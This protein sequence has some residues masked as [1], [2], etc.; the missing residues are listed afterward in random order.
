MILFL[1][2]FVDE[3]VFACFGLVVIWWKIGSCRPD[4]WTW[5]RIFSVDR[6]VLAA[7]FAVLLHGFIRY[8]LTVSRGFHL[9][10]GDT[11]G[12]GF[13]TMRK[14]WTVFSPSILAPFKGLSLFAVLAA[15]VAAANRKWAVL[16]STTVIVAAVLVQ[17]FAVRK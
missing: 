12:V 16:I 10:L 2:S 9:P 14:G 3:R 11:G 5:R 6:Y 17:S 8:Y 7:C 15:I 1:A 4:A 13:S